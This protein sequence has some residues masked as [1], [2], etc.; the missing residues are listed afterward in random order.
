MAGLD[1]RLAGLG[2]GQGL[3]V[4]LGI[5]ILLGLRHAT[6]P[7]HLTAVATL[8]A[9]DARHRVRSAAR[10]GLAWGAGHAV[11]LLVLGLP[12]VLVGDALPETAQRAAELLVGLVIIGLAVRLLR[13]WRD[14]ELH[15]HE[16]DH[17]SGV[18]HVHPHAHEQAHGHAHAAHEHRHASLG[19][20]PRAAFAIGLVHGIGGSAGVG[21][22]LIGA[23]SGGAAAVTALA[24]FAAGTAVSMALVTT[25]FAAALATRPAQRRFEALAPALGTAAL[26]FGAWYAVAAVVA[27]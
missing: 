21:V 6:D 9:G 10:L 7:D 19:R 17:R 8:V 24:L 2:G 3:L 11:T 5:A 26:A 20:T 25:A 23:V 16:H 4:A 1:E 14:G 12:V 13:R 18:R 22:L 15:L 27:V